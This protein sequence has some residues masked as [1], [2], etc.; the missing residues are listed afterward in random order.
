MDPNIT[1]DLVIHIGAIEFISFIG[2]VLLCT[3][4]ISNKLGRVETKVDGFE[5]RFTNLEG[6]LDNSFSSASPIALQKKG[7]II[8]ED[9][10]LKKY[11]DEK[12][13]ILL[14]KCKEKR[15]MQNQYDIQI[16]AFKFF[17]DFNFGDF[18]ESLKKSAYKHGVSMDIVRRI[19]GIY[20]R[21]I[22]LSHLGFTPEDLDKNPKVKG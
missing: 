5:T 13:D 18:E 2:F 12:K 21:D 1:R 17:D 8:L 6:R 19:A 15:T 9:S 4:F 3:W 16:S 14:S 11:I 22:C 7:T 20:F 10:G